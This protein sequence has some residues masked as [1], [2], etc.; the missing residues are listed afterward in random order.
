[1]LDTI[2]RPGEAAVMVTPR[3]MP[4]LTAW[5]GRYSFTSRVFLKKIFFYNFLFLKCTKI[6][7]NTSNLY[8]S[9]LLS[10]LFEFCFRFGG[11]KYFRPIILFR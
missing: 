8:F 1:M 9:N 3:D 4:F 10:P 2:E 6:S 7:R 5:R 11:K